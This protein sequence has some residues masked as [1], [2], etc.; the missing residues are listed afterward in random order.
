MLTSSDQVDAPLCDIFEVLGASD[1]ILDLPF[2]AL[3]RR[4][5][6]LHHAFRRIKAFDMI[7]VLRKL[8]GQLSWTTTEVHCGR[9]AGRRLR[10]MVLD[11][12]I[13]DLG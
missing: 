3:W 2:R 7:E 11:D 4:H 13:D 9:E 12:D 6:V 5:P 8:N 10:G 1:S